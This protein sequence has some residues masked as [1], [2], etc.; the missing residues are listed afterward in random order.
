[1][2]R[3]FPGGK[4]ASQ[5]RK[6]CHFIILGKNEIRRKEHRVTIS[7]IISRTSSMLEHFSFRSTLPTAASY[8]GQYPRDR[9]IRETA[10]IVFVSRDRTRWFVR[11]YPRGNRRADGYTYV[12]S[13]FKKTRRF[14]AISIRLNER[15]TRKVNFDDSLFSGEWIATRNFLSTL[16]KIKKKK[17]KTRLPLYVPAD[18][19]I[20]LILNR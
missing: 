3:L 4:S 14:D 1:M 11:I 15:T 2:F 7:T 19:D 18:G 16:K 10:T 6:D 9:T 17:I 12:S 5:N 20:S 13:P 8:N